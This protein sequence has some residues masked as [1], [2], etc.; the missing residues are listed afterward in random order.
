MP[1]LSP[2]PPFAVVKFSSVVNPLQWEI[3]QRQGVGEEFYP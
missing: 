2:K 3:P 1:Y